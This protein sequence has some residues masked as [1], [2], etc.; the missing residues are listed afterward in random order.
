MPRGFSQTYVGGVIRKTGGVN[1]RK[2]LG[3]RSRRRFVGR[4][5]IEQSE[6]VGVDQSAITFLGKG[7]EGE[8]PLPPKVPT[9]GTGFSYSVHLLRRIFSGFSCSVPSTQYG[10]E[11]RCLH[12]ESS[13]EYLRTYPRSGGRLGI[14]IRPPSCLSYG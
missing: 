12:T 8:C 4:I 14:M 9:P 5:V 2:S 6:N 7:G 1:R 3:R 11:Q 13:M 10:T